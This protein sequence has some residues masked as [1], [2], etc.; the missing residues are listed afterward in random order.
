MTA[1]APVGEP[2]EQFQVVVLADEQLPHLR[3]RRV[4][5]GVE[6]AKREPERDP[7]EREHPPQLPSPD[8]ADRGQVTK[9]YLAG[10]GFASTDSVC[11]AR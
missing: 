4:R 11:S 2:V 7:G 3:R 5:G 6:E 1:A 9:C 8:D 10:S